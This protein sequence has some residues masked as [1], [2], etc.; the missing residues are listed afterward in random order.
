VSI[1][2]SALSIHAK[3]K[4]WSS[5]YKYDHKLGAQHIKDPK[6][7]MGM[8]AWFNGI[9]HKGINYIISKLYMI[10]EACEAA[11]ST[12]IIGVVPATTRII[13]FI[14]D[15]EQFMS[16]TISQTDMY[17]L[18]SPK[19]FHINC[20]HTYETGFTPFIAQ[21]KDKYIP[22]FPRNSR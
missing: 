11:Q 20:S 17:N 4:K 6:Q 22:P 21:G 9:H 10:H 7:L 5:I 13:D 3:F 16:I 14:K 12:L 19:L 1:D 8:R 15:K 18:I 2:D